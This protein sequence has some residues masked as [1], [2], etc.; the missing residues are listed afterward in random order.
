[1][2]KNL[3]TTKAA[4]ILLFMGLF[5][6]AAN[7]GFAQP[8]K[9][10][11]EQDKFLGS[12]EIGEPEGYFIPGKSGQIT[13]P[14]NV[15]RLG[16]A[17]G[18]FDVRVCISEDFTSS[19]YL[20]YDFDVNGYIPGQGIIE[21]AT[22]QQSA[23]G[24]LTIYY[25]GTPEVDEDEV[26]TFSI[27]GYVLPANNNENYNCQNPT[28]DYAEASFEGTLAF[29]YAPTI[30]CPDNIELTT[31]PGV[32]EA[33]TSWSLTFVDDDLADLTAGQYNGY[34]EPDIQYA[35][36]GDNYTDWTGAG[37]TFPKGIN[38]VILIASN[39]ILPD[40]T[41]SFTVTVADNEAPTF[42]VPAAY[43][44]I[45]DDNCDY[46]ADP[47]TTG[48]PTD[49]SD[50]C[51]EN[52]AVT[53][54]DIVAVGSC[55]DETIVT[56]TWKVED[57]DGN[58][59][60]DI[61]ILT[62][63]DQ[64]KP[65]FTLP[66]DWTEDKDATCSY[67]SDPNHTGVPTELWDNCDTDPT[68]TYEDADGTP[69]C[70][71]ETVILRTWKIEDN[72]GNVTTGVQTL[73]FEDNTNPTFTL[74][75]DWTEDKDA[76]CSYDSDPNHTG[77]PTELRDNC[78]ADPT[79]TYEDANGTP[80]CPD[81]TVIL[82]TWKIE[83]NCGNVTTGVQTL[84]FEDNTNPT[85]TLPADWTEDKDETCSYDD[86]PDNTG[87]PTEL[88]DNCDT[89]PTVT[90]ED[91]EGTPSCPDE[92]VILRTWKIEDNCGNVTTG[93]QTLT[94]E[95]N[96]P[97]T[98]TLPAD[99]T[100]DKDATCSYDA[101]PDNTGYPTE[102]WD[103]CDA[104][105]TVTYEDADG[106]P[107]CP[108]E[109]VILRTWKIED[110]CGNVTTGTQ[111]ITF[112][113]NNPPTFTAPADITVYKDE[114]CEYVVTVDI[115]GDVEDE[116]DNCTELLE[117][118][119]EDAYV[120]PADACDGLTV[121]ERTWSLVDDCGN[122]AANQVQT[123]TIE[124]N[125]PP[126]VTC[127]DVE[128][129]YLTEEADPCNG[130]EL[131]FEATAVDNCSET[132]VSYSIG[133]ET[134]ESFPYNF[135]V[136]TTT[137]LVTATDDCGNSSTCEFDVVVK[138]PTTTEAFVSAEAARYCDEVTLFAE[139][140]GECPDYELTGNVEFFLDGTSVGSAP[141]FPIPEGE[142]DARKLRA[143]LIYKIKVIPK[144]DYDNDAWV[145]TAEFTPTSDN[146]AGSEGET[147]LLIYPRKIDP[148]VAISGFYTDN[149]LAWTTGPNASSGTI[150]MAAIMKDNN[151]PSGDLRG[152]EVTFC[153]VEG[154]GEDMVFKPIPS[155]KKL[156]AGLISVLDGTYG[157]AS[158]DVQVDI[159]KVDE[160]KIAVI[161]S[162]GYI[163]DSDA[164][165]AIATVSLAKP[166]AGNGTAE[167]EGELI[168]SNSEGMIKGAIGES[169]H[170]NFNVQ[171]NQ[172]Q[173]NP[174][175]SMTIELVSWYKPDGTLDG[176]PHTY[177]IK[178]NA[179]NLFVLGE[180]DGMLGTNQAI[181]DAKAN[182]SERMEDGTL[183]DV[184]GNSPLHVTIVDGDMENPEGIDS[185]GITYYR[186]DG[187]VWFS[188]YWDWTAVGVLANPVTLDQ[189]IEEGGDITISKDPEASAQS[190]KT[191]SASIA[192]NSDPFAEYEVEFR[193]YPNPFKDRTRFE[194]AS[195]VSAH[196]KID[197]FDL[198]GRMV[199]TVFDNYVEEN[200]H[201]SAEFKPENENSG[202]Y[203][204]RL[205]LGDAIYN[206]KLIYKNE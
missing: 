162:G 63:A 83:D 133:E 64:T 107:S 66:A 118:T 51:D 193:I 80:S 176:E 56:R 7:A 190:S 143:T 200:A 177:V 202:M 153:F 98:F 102:F 15:T 165:P 160:I 103:N 204:Y 144:D 23:S 77:V 10:K 57:E 168:N 92:T 141:A 113:D 131:S 140:D 2:Y 130:I 93:V 49:I 86:H 40:A 13:F 181:F 22:Q 147:S 43:N 148:F 124:D 195:P 123:I 185:I 171:Y 142:D 150:T 203:F 127:P 192:E 159:K 152:A 100:E 201:Y 121:I 179:I 149:M 182:L 206:G 112:E 163:N 94:F 39:G 1:M 174:Q 180:I 87:Y 29:G 11:K 50:N 167:G 62:F 189:G 139:I 125:T 126:V 108:D 46:D 20:T 72:C 24:Q 71:D 116:A 14:V 128:E 95:D 18:N 25:D 28:N 191:K 67:D 76:T 53:F 120:T 5:L 156:P 19:G 178:S 111:I 81:E 9:P 78:D 154:E 173:T 84:T 151:D 170:F 75:A 115:T 60:T 106:T 35:L 119:F 59:S 91:A 65:T 137:V 183:V 4:L 158:A 205:Q 109:T 74:P 194:F 169:T 114:N 161:L 37:V 110:N 186:N 34:P 138:I 12:I 166:D 85:F 129:Y 105:P 99:W 199:Q 55:P 44:G 41:C 30:V 47:N 96:T 136:G 69:S 89:D 104:D 68:V 70:P 45:K 32:C 26:W 38:T 8:D 122:E 6:L 197:I 42:T 135:P 73:T 31:E 54:S 134:I 3:R 48:N 36:N 187:G 146:Y 27:A 33:T 17:Q 132:S 61:Q 184:D 97:P 79:V 157:A 188:S 175:G 82:R 172:K 88:R 16:P 198:A 52:P 145:V 90:Y 101:D 117:A 196:A 21:V 155:A 58:F 164:E